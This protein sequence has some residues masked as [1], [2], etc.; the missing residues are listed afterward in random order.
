MV[1]V[2]IGLESASEQDS[3][4]YSCGKRGQKRIYLQLQPVMRKKDRNYHASHKENT[5][6]EDQMLVCRT[7][8]CTDTW[9]VMSSLHQ[10]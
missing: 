9:Q 5:S 10:Q 4:H 3:F 8:Y 7:N 1:A 2:G 6:S